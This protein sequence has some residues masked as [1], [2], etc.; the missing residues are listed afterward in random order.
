MISAHLDCVEPC[1]G[2]N[3]KV[4]DGLVFSAGETV[5]GADDKVGLASAIECIRRLAEGERPYP[6]VRCVFTVQEEIGLVGA[7]HLAAADI[8]ADLCLVLDAAGK[9]GGVVIGAPTHYTFEASFLGRAAHAGVEPEKGV[10]AIKMAG[11]AI[12]A[13]PIG[14]LDP[15]TT[16]N[17]GTVQGGTATNVITAVAEI[18]GECRS[19]DR[20]RVEAVKAEMDATMRRAAS[21]G[22]GSVEI[23]WTLEYEGFKLAQ[24][25]DLVRTVTEACVDVGLE[26]S[27]FVT[28]G[29]SDANI[30]S[31]KGAPV[32][33]LSCGMQGVH[34]IDESV[35]V[36]D[37]ENLTELVT[38]IAWRLAE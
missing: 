20:D 28:G 10:S 16:A 13:L 3:P 38:A 1:R 27:T 9:P 29:G 11:E 34:S 5:L 4:A 33:A 23:A 35:A 30:I 17:V 19:L 37:L 12:A 14:R 2:V 8:A 32:L 25:D 31:A 26:P 36:V 21:E 24:D 18:T 22:G 7:K 15:E 6:T